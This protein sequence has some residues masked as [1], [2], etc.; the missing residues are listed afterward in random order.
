MWHGENSDRNVVKT[1]HINSVVVVIIQTHK[2]TTYI[3]STI[4]YIMQILQ[5]LTEMSKGKV[6][7]VTGPVWSRGWVK[8]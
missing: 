3:V 8:V 2:C 6:I 5:P 4:F 1:F 7:P